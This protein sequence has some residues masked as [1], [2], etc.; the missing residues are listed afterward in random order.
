MNDLY[1]IDENS[2]WEMVLG[3]IQNM[4][5]YLDQE[6]MHNQI[7]LVASGRAVC[8]LQ[9]AVSEKMGAY[10]IA[11]YKLHMGIFNLSSSKIFFTFLQKHILYILPNTYFSF[12]FPLRL[13][14]PHTGNATVH[15]RF[16]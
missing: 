13:S 1:H 9:D 8:K 11:L 14:F 6:S 5:Q 15:I 3:N 12:S 7:D 4:I 16:L 10:E 2:K